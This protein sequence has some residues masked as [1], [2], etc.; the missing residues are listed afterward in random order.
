MENILKDVEN[1]EDFRNWLEINCL[2]EKQ[3]YV[4]IQMKKVKKGVLLYIDAVYEALCFGWIDSVTR[5]D[6]NGRLLQ[7]FSP[8]RK[9]SNWTELNKERARFL[10]KSGQMTKYGEA[11]LPDLNEKFII[12]PEILNIF[13]KDEEFLQKIKE[14]PDL[15]FRI[16]V[17]NIQK[18]KKNEEL[19]LKRINKFIDMTKKGKM[20]GRWNDF[21]RLIQY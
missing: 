16:R 10:K 4:L 8:R 12:D 14:F 15:Y 7:R 9:K 21:G 6:S 19:F 11:V 18:V 13:E 17:D 3:C 2:K 5:K 1:R 20:F